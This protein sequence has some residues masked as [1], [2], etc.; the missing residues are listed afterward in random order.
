MLINQNYNS[1]KSDITSTIEKLIEDLR[2]RERCLHAE[3]EVY[4]QAQLRT[5]SIE[6]ENAEFDLASV[7][8]FCDSSEAA[9]NR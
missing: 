6:K 9:L 7:S 1:I 8:S 4:M 5:I 3:A 2:N